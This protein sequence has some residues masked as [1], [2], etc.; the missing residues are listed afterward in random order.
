MGINC[1]ERKPFWVDDFE[2]SMGRPSSEP[3]TQSSSD[4]I[5]LH[6]LMLCKVAFFWHCF[7]VLVTR[8]HLI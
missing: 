6:D 8:L 3:N 4:D 2:D 1:I 5:L 7:F